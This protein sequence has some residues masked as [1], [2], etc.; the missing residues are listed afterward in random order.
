MHANLLACMANWTLYTLEKM[1]RLSFPRRS[2]LLYALTVWWTAKWAHRLHNY[3]HGTL[4]IHLCSINS[5]LPSF[6]PLHHLHFKL[7]HAFSRYSV[8]QAPER[9]AGSGNE[10][11]YTPVKPF[12]SQILCKLQSLSTFT[13]NNKGQGSN[14]LV[15]K[16]FRTHFKGHI[17]ASL[18]Y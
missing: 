4:T 7:F 8:R 15:N 1:P 5:S 18:R 2:N 17:F 6:Y 16:H 10:P 13:A 3:M 9:W 14:F 11:S 12:N